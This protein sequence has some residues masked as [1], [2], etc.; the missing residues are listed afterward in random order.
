MKRFIM[1]LLLLA[2]SDSDHEHDFVMPQVIDDLNTAYIVLTNPPV[3]GDGRIKYGSLN[4][5]DYLEKDY[6]KID[7]S[8]KP[9][10]LTVNDYPDPEGRTVI[11]VETWNLTGSRLQLYVPCS[12]STAGGV[13]SVELKWC[14]GATGVAGAWLNFSCVHGK[15]HSK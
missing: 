12:E 3:R 10:G 6:I 14:A 4:D 5:V 15:E 13:V 8:K 7:F 1:I 9:C 2:C 11:P